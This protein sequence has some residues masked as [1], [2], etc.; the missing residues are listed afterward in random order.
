MRTAGEHQEAR[1]APAPS[2][3]EL[4]LVEA[5]RRREEAAFVELVE[6]Y[7][8]GL[9]RLALT[10]VRTRAVAEEVV[11]ET[12]LGVLKGIDRFEGRSSLR[13]WI[14]RILTNVAK[15]RAVRE[16]RTVPFA[17]LE[18]ETEEGPLLDPSRF[19][20][21]GEPWEGHWQWF[22][23]PW[24]EPEERLLASEARGVIAAVIEA[25]PPGQRAVVTLRDVEGWNSEETCNALAISETNQRVLLHRARTKVR[26]AL[27]AYL[28][29]VAGGGHGRDS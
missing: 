26:L 2:P 4:A 21:T 12:W 19:V 6:S 27:E 11:Q 8:A 23:G 24:G 25:L 7:G 13:T 18:S 29:E 3:D 5:L 17:D 28:T 20:R 22:P 16:G 14:F 15:T 1:L 9:L 10:F